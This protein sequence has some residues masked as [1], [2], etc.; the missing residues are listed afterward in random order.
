MLV[1]YRLEDLPNLVARHGIGAW[2][3]PSLWPETFS[4]VTQESLATGLPCIGFDLGGQGDALR[5]AGNGH[6]V[7]L[8]N[9]GE[10]DL[11][12]LLAGLRVLP[13]WPV[14]RDRTGSV[15]I[16]NWSFRRGRA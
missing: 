7:A 9:G 13:G 8:R 15:S 10:V 14:T 2:L 16:R 6:V 5:R 11:D 12:T 1:G 4:Y 3:I